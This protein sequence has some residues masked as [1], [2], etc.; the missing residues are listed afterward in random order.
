[1]TALIV[2]MLTQEAQRAKNKML[3]SCHLIE[4]LLIWVRK[5]SETEISGIFRNI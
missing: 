4:Q 1:M 2:P 5:I 3:I